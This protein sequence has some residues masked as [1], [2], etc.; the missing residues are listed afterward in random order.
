MSGREHRRLKDGRLV[1]ATH[2][3][4]KL[5]EIAELL[6]PFDVETVSVGALGLPEPEETGSTFAE[7]AE[8]KALAAARASGFPALADDSGIC[9][10]ALDGAPGIYSARWAG[11]NKDFASA[12]ARV[13]AEL[14]ARRVPQDKWTAHF[15]SALTLAWPDGHVESFEGRV[16]GHLTFPPRGGKGFGYDP[17]FVPEGHTE[18]YGELEPEYKHTMSHRALAFAKLIAACFDE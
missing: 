6:R 5:R 4:G 10:D 11:E 1:V 18:T 14:D 9:I 3:P 8:L 2:N 12:M 17:I 13:K 7:N 15:I 16:D